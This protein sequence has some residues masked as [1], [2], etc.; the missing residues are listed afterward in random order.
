MASRLQKEA[1]DLE[2]CIR[3]AIRLIAGRTATDDE[4]KKDVAFVRELQEKAKLSESAA[5]QQYCL[6]VLNTNEFVYLD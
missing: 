4:V 2:S 6:L 5:L 1:A 3:R